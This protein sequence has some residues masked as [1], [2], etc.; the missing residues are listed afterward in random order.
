MRTSRVLSRAA[1]VAPVVLVLCCWLLPVRCAVA[2]RPSCRRAAPCVG[3]PAALANGQSL[4]ILSTRGQSFDA[5]CPDVQRYDGRRW[6]NSS[7]DEFLAADQPGVPT[8]LFIHGAITSVKKADESLWACYHQVTYGSRRP[9]RLV[10]W[11][12]PSSHTRGNRLIPEMRSQAIRADGEAIA[13]AQVLARIQPSVPV[14][15]FGYSFGC[16]TAL[17][18]MH[19]AGGGTIGGRAAA[20]PVTAEPRRYRVVLLGSAT[21]SRGLLPGGCYERALDPVESVLLFYNHKDRMLKKYRWLRFSDSQV[22]LGLTGMAGGAA[23]GA[24]QSKIRTA[25]AYPF[26]RRGHRWDKYE[27]SGILPCYVRSYANFE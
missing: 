5:P 22:A 1:H 18:A 11:S 25:D 17:A 7:M 23:L 13:V 26:V 6:V 4:W 14:C 15:V 20:F 16:R 27:P 19:L 9:C 3:G 2:A 12:W 24:N 21:D 10:L 8:I